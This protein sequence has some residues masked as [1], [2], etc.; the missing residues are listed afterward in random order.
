VA[1]LASPLP[2]VTTWWLNAPRD[3]YP[4]PTRWNIGLHRWTELFDF[5]LT[6]VAGELDAR[7]G[8]V[9]LSLLPLLLGVRPARQLHRWVP[10][11]VTLLVFFF[12]PTTIAST[13][14]LYPRAA[15]F[16]LPMLLFA[17][18]P[19]SEPR[20]LGKVVASA[21]PALL[22]VITSI[23]Y[24]A[25]DREVADF[26]DVLSRLEPHRRV[27]YLP[28]NPVSQFVSGRVFMHFGCYYQAER[29]GVADFSFA[30][31]HPAYFRY[32]P[33]THP[34]LPGVEWYPER[35][36]YAINGPR[37]DYLLVRGPVLRS[38]FTHMRLEDF[39]VLSAPGGWQVIRRDA[40]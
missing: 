17:L 29:G 11:L 7:A 40:R 39:I 22:L 31:L 5:Q 14:F 34:H 30:E 2:L 33:K 27:L 37:F 25:Y 8:A 21:A 4:V 9:L 23:R 19:R 24:I 18:D 35:F 12:A 10:L 16:F 28:V 32:K 26:R 13:A 38:W 3:P 20:A 36:R 6:N 1:A 15:V